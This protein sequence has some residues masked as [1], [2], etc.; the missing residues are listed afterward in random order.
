MQ[1]GI[2]GGALPQALK[3]SVRDEDGNAIAGI[4]VAFNAS[5]GA[6]VA[7]ASAVT[8]ASGEAETLLRMPLMEGVALATAEANR[9]VVTFSA[10][11][12]TSA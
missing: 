4:L 12:A 6:Q 8:N 1:V 5:P 9:Q 3:V 2:P 10:R 11:G 7:P